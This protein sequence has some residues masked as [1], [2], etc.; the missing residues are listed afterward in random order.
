MIIILMKRTSSR[1]RFDDIHH[2]SDTTLGRLSYLFP[3]I[4]RV[5]QVTYLGTDPTENF[6]YRICLWADLF[7]MFCNLQN[8]SKLFRIDRNITN[9][10]CCY[11]CCCAATTQQAHTRLATKILTFVHVQFTIRHAIANISL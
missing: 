11:C 3:W 4:K 5:F 7:L 6:F 8:R 10:C 9:C 2:S 1:P